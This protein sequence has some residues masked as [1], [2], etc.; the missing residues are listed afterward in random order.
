MPDRFAQLRADRPNDTLL[1][2]ALEA[3]FGSYM[4]FY[5]VHKRITGRPPYPSR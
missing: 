4:Q 2:L 5:R 3:G 1:A